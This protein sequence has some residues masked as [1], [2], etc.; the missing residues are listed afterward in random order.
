MGGR[1]AFSVQP[2]QFQLSQLF[3]P[4]ADVERFECRSAFHATALGTLAISAALYIETKSRAIPRA[5]R[6]RPLPHPHLA[7]PRFRRTPAS[8]PASLPRSP[9]M[10]IPAALG[11]GNRRLKRGHGVA[12]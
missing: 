3:D 10:S 6:P 11:R 4:G 12:D 1:E 2:P 8:R 7:V 5:I 9:D